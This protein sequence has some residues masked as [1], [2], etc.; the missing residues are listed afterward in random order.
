V[1]PEWN[2][3]VTRTNGGR[4][5]GAANRPPNVDEIWSGF[6]AGLAE[7]IAPQPGPIRLH[8]DNP[9]CFLWRGK[10]T[11]LIT[12][13]EH[14]GAVMD[15]GYATARISRFVPSFLSDSQRL[16]SRSKGADAHE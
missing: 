15:F 2:M 1:V 13:G 16:S 14:Y 9:H 8:P 12:S 7:A 6:F 11:V 5:D 10:P 4:K 3:V